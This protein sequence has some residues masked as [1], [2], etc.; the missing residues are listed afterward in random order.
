MSPSDPLTLAAV[1]VLFIVAG[2]VACLGPAWRAT[3]ANPLVAL[4][5][6]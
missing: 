3:T 5:G 1:G 4:R 2:C 6:E